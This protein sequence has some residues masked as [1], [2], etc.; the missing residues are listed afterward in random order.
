MASFIGI[1]LGTTYSAVSYID[2]T[3]RSKIVHNSDGANVT[4]SCIDFSGGKAVVGE[5]A[6]RALGL[7]DTIAA[8]FKRDMGSTSKIYSI[9]GNEYTPS[10]CSAII[11]KKLLQ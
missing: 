7:S 11:L 4:P 5:E 8:R 2:D 9:E 10:D 6:R 1:D 3:G